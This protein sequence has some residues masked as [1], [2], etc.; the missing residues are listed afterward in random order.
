MSVGE[1][2]FW[3]KKY[4]IQSSWIFH[5][6]WKFSDYFLPL[7]WFQTRKTLFI[8]GKQIKIFLTKS[9]SFL[10]LHRQQNNWNVQGLER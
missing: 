8:F 4:I 3:N 1:A 6:K 5:P 2:S 9:E 7:L 10:T